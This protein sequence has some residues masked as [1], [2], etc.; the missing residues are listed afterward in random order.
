MRGFLMLAA[1]GLLTAVS[2]CG[3][4]PPVD[5]FKIKVADDGEVYT[6]ANA[7]PLPPLDEGRIQLAGPKGWKA[8]PR[9]FSHLARFDTGARN[10][11]PRIEITVEESPYED[12][13]TLTK[14]NVV[15]FAKVVDKKIFAEEP[16]G[17][18]ASPIFEPPK[19]MIIGGVPCVRY[20][21]PVN[22]RSQN[23]VYLVE[24][25]ILETIHE[26]RLYRV[27]L[28]VMEGTILRYRDAGYSVLASIQFND[29]AQEDGAED[30]AGGVPKLG[31]G[32]DGAESPFAS[33]KDE[34]E[35][36]K[37]PK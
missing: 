14:D 29:A 6:F 2:G 1:M 12:F 22:L 30:A 16:P 23:T 13:K 34:K 27:E 19:P 32:S 21:L 26:G 25:Q 9:D 10:G 35:D 24:R 8:L 17:A 18:L 3:G 33:K 31:E 37:T 4:K 20:V 5:R 28:R 15:A 11:L 7:D 36:G